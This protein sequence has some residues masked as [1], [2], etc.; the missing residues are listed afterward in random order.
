LIWLGPTATVLPLT[1][2]RASTNI[3]NI[4]MRWKHCRGEDS[5][6]Q[7]CTIPCR[8]KQQRHRR[9][10]ALQ[11]AE[12]RMRISGWAYLG[13]QSPLTPFNAT[14]IHSATRARHLCFSLMLD[15]P[16]IES[17]HLQVSQPPIHMQRVRKSGHSIPLPLTFKIRWTRQLA[18][19]LAVLHEQG[20]VHRVSQTA[21]VVRA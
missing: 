18:A 6:R 2:I 20:F 4:E 9:I 5:A 10:F 19:G 14:T 8:R 12:G 21:I 1:H 7:Q 16:T 17:S 3:S 13:V 11:L 15:V